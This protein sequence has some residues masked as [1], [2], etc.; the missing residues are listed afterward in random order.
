[1]AKIA[2]FFSGDPIMFH[3]KYIVICCD[4]TMENEI[5]HMSEADLVARSR[6][7]TNV[8]KTVLLAYQPVTSEEKIKYKAIQWTEKE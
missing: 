3:A 7:A 6:L 4:N 2:Y 5:E 8:K 1:M